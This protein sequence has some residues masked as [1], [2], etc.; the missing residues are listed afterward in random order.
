MFKSKI[1]KPYVFHD[2]ERIC[3]GDILRDFSFYYINSTNEVIKGFYNYIIIITQD[4][5]LKSYFEKKNNTDENEFFNQF[6]PSILFIPAFPLDIIKE[7]EHLIGIYKIKQ[8]RLNSSKID[9]IKKQNETRYHFLPSY[10]DYQIP[11][12]I[13]DFKLYYT[14]SFDYTLIHYINYYLGTVNEIYRE[15]LSQRFADYLNRIGLPV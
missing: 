15:R 13:I 11:E 7:G 4:C 14:V 8:E 3:Q 5:D 2:R 12:L 6:V 9:R 10:K 1:E